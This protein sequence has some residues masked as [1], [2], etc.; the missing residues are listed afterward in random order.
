MDMIHPIISQGYWVVVYN[1][2]LLSL[3]K[4]Y[5]NLNSKNFYVCLFVFMCPRTQLGRY[6]IFIQSIAITM[7]MFYCTSM[8]SACQMLFSFVV[9]T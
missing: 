6:Y 9:F 2:Y 4:L 5:Y 7:E 8:M 3:V 1:V